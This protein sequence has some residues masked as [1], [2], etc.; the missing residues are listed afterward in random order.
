MDASV[1]ESA[2]SLITAFDGHGLRTRGLDLQAQKLMKQ[3]LDAVDDLTRERD[4]LIE[5]LTVNG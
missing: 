3:L 5:R 1:R 2:E 4:Q